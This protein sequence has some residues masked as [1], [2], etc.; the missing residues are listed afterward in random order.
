M[1]YY[2]NSKILLK[3]NLK[4]AYIVK[5]NKEDN[6]FIV[7]YYHNNKMVYDKIFNDDIMTEDEYNIY[8]NRT[9]IINDILKS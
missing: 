1:K 7:S 3:K 9:N 4:L 8:K 5:I 6:S 2:I